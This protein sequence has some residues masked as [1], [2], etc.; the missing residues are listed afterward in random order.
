[1]RAE[2]EMFQRLGQWLRSRRQPR[3]NFTTT[4]LRRH[5]DHHDEGGVPG[6]VNYAKISYLVSFILIFSVN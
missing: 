2:I 1:M 5:D 3:R 6:K 4:S